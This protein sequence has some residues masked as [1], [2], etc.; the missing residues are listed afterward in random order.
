MDWLLYLFFAIGVVS[1][2]IFL[3]RRN[4]KDKRDLENQL[5]RTY[6]GSEKKESDIETEDVVK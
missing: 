2:L 4:L 1:L 3:V 5:N 6:F